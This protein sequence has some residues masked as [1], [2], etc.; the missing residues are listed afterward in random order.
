MDLKTSL[1]TAIKTGKVVLGTNKTE[2]TLLIGSPKLVIVSDD[3]KDKEKIK[4]FCKLG[5]VKCKILKISSIS[6]GELCGKPFPVS[7]LAIINPG[8]SNILNI[9]N[10]EQ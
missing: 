8:E 1:T 5:N 7:A 2:K 9:E 3:N 6:L 4:Y 10:W